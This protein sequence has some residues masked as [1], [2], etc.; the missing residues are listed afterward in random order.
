MSVATATELGNAATNAAE[1]TCSDETLTATEHEAAWETRVTFRTFPILGHVIWVM[2]ELSSRLLD[3]M[4]L[5]DK[6]LFRCT[7]RSDRQRITTH[8]FVE[9]VLKETLRQ[10]RFLSEPRC[11]NHL[12]QTS[13]QCFA[14]CKELSVAMRQAQL[15]RKVLRGEIP[16]GQEALACT[17]ADLKEM[18]NEWRNDWSGEHYNAPPGLDRQS[19]HRRRRS[20]FQ[21]YL[22]RETGG[23]KRLLLG[24]L[25]FDMIHFD[26]PSLPVLVQLLADLF[27]TSEMIRAEQPA[28]LPAHAGLS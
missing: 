25:R 3:L 23:H 12:V 26:L 19:L 17:N 2:P 15:A 10:R 11:L 28:L 4:R 14:R 18:L 7:C 13:D 16:D 22:F 20:A 5:Q 9:Q 24:F 1:N 8:A 21:A 27:E 6:A